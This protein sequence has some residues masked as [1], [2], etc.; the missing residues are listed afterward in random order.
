M[1]YISIYFLLA[2]LVTGCKKDFLQRDPGAPITEDNVFGDPVLAARFADA[3]YNYMIDEFGRMSQGYKGTTGQFCDEAVAAAASDSYPFISVMTSG[4]FL[5]P[6]ATDV[7]DVYTRMYR[8]IRNTNVMLSKLDSVPWTAAQSPKLI[9]AQM[10]F[11][12]GMFYFELVKRFGGVV[13]LNKPLTEEDEVDLPRNTY[14]ESVNFILKDLAEA[15]SLFAT[16]TFVLTSGRVYSPD[17]DWDTRNFG[18]ATA[19][20][21]KALRLRLLVLDASPNRNPSGTA[22]KWK[23]AADAA[24]E[25]ISW[26]RY[27]LQGLYSEVLNRSTSTEYIMIKVRGPRSLG[28]MLSDFI[29]PPSSGGAQGLLNPTHNHVDLYEMSNG[30]PI[31]EPG[32]GYNPQAPYANRDPRFYNNLIYNDQAWQGRRIQMYEGGADYVPASNSTTRTRYYCKRL[33]PEAIRG[34][35]NATGLVNFIFFRYAEV[36]LNYAEA[37]NEAEGPVADVYTYVNQIRTR[38]RMPVLPDGLTKEQ[39][40]KRIR[41]ERAVE[42]A[43]EEMRWWDLLR[44]RDGETI[45]AT[46]TAMDVIKTASGFTYQVVPLPSLYQREFH[47]RMFTYPIPRA[48]VDKSNGVMKQ[49]P[50]W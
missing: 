3:S 48:E 25:I 1:K 24:K 13:L 22:A 33:W 46:V 15:E 14:D 49:N 18:R 11:L 41:N 4:K 31:H 32:S 6:I 28:G 42:F 29:M 26:N 40:R 37:L 47:E 8:G 12:R 9:K 36:L 21:V 2:I 50:G 19:G 23:K 45:S 5:D 43:F 7:A 17:L 30:K 27:A 34:N 35:S 44:W 10:L 16:T 39:M 20:A 38:A